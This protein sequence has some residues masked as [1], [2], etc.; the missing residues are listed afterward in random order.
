VRRKLILK[1]SSHQSIEKSK[2]DILANKLSAAK[3][4]LEDGTGEA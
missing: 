1:R 4:Y 2:E 3:N